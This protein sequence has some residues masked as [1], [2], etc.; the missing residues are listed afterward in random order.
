M[1]RHNPQKARAPRRSELDGSSIQAGD[2]GDSDDSYAPD[3]DPIRPR[4]HRASHR[5]SR[6]EDASITRGPELIMPSMHE[7]AGGSWVGEEKS[8]RRPPRKADGLRKSQVLEQ[9]ARRSPTRPTQQSTPE[10]LER[11]LDKTIKPLLQGLYDILSTTFSLL[12]TPVAYMLA[13]YLLL[14][15]VVFSKNLLTNSIT[16]ALSPMC[17]LPLASYVVPLC[18]STYSTTG[19]ATLVPFDGLM[20]EQSKFEDVLEVSAGGAS[21]PTDMKRCELSIRDL[22]TLVR[23]SHLS[24]RNELGLEFDGFIETAQIASFDLQKFNSHVGRGV[25]N[26]LATARWT[27]RVLDGIEARD[28]ERGAV[29]SFFSDTLFAPFQPLRYSENAALQQYMRHTRT[30]E[31]EI[32]RLVTEAQAVLQVLQNLEDRLDVIHGIAVHDQETAQLSRDDI[33][34]QLWTKLGGNAET[35]G[36]LHSKLDLLDHVNQHRQSAFAHVGGMIVRLQEIAAGLE[37]LRER[38]GGVDVVGGRMGV[39]LSVIIEIVELGVQ[40]L[41]DARLRTRGVEGSAVRKIL[42]REGENEPR[43][44]GA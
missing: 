8:R 27:R 10:A 30:V 2:S 31:D 3:E 25:D 42:D 26:V 41:Q 32:A 24:S 19:D 28:V 12:K 39:P 43:L 22:R 44:I 35:L 34:A 7:D 5:P 18:K 13:V 4:Q 17:R 37:D 9:Q 40:S 15:M 16:N 23:H 20:T 36:K 1:P 21:L 14:G 33:L 6:E 29:M 38:V 11:V